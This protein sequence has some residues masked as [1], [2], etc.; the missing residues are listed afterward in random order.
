VCIV[1][2]GEGKSLIDFKL[3]LDVLNIMGTKQREEC[4][5]LV[6]HLCDVGT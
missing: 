3:K 6:K 1:D 4:F 5:I 2:M